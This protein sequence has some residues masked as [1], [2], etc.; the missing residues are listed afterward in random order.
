MLIDLNRV[1]DIDG[2]SFRDGF[3]RIEAMT[4]Q[5]EIEYSELVAKHAP[6]L[7]TAI[8]FVGNPAARNRGTLGG[9]IVFADPNAD[10]G[11]AYIRSCY[12]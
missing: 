6:L 12:A 11:P 3:L 7:A 10:A 1:A 4:R 8:K 9:S 5:R 2:I